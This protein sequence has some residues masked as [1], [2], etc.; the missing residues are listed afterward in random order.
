MQSIFIIFEYSYTNIHYM[1]FSVCWP[2]VLVTASSSF[3]ESPLSGLEGLPC[4]GAF[5]SGC[6]AET[7]EGCGFWAQDPTADQR[8]GSTR[9]R[10]L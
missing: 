9:T 5:I 2:S 10:V 8:Q 6:E 1:K 3:L 4:P 7:S